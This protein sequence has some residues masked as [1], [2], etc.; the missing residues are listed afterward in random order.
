MG[1]SE[2]DQPHVTQGLWVMGP[3]NNREKSVGSGAFDLKS[4]L[5]AEIVI[6]SKWSKSA[7][8]HWGC[9][10]GSSVFSVSRGW[11]LVR[12]DAK[13]CLCL[14]LPGCRHPS[15]SLPALSPLRCLPGA[16]LNELQ[17]HV[18][19]TSCK[20]GGRWALANRGRLCER[21]ICC[22]DGVSRSSRLCSGRRRLTSRLYALKVEVSSVSTE[23]AGLWIK[24]LTRRV[25]N[26]AERSA[27]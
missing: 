23:G 2:W 24:D 9:H 17:R 26:W 5:S 6:N 4:F 7:S 21:A 1:A 25:S 18:S 14:L 15:Q 16:K 13:S 10:D 12:V 19:C 11:W 20:E 22:R 8:W 3:E 27:S